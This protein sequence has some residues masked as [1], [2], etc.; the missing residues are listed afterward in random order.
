MLAATEGT[1]KKLDGQQLTT[2]QQDMVRQV[3][4]FMQQSRNAVRAGDFAGARTLALKAQQLS[5]E[6]VQSGK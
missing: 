6:L 3:R 1:L 2:S 4:Q 5:E